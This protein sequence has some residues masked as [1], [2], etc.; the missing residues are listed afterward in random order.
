MRFVLGLVGRTWFITVVT[1]IICAGFLAKA[2]NSI[3]EAEAL[4][5]APASKVPVVAPPKPILAARTKLDGTKISRNIFCSTCEPIVLVDG[6]KTYT[7]EPAVLIATMLGPDPRAT[8]RVLASEAQGSWGIGERIPGVGR[9]DRIGSTSIDVVDV[10]GHVG[11][12]SLLDARAE[13]QPKKTDA[14]TSVP[15]APA[16]PFADRVRKIADNDY[17]VDRQL[18]RDLVTGTSKPNGVRAVPQ[19]KGSEV[20][21]IRMIGVRGGSVAAAL[22]L[23]SNDVIAAIDG[24]PIKNVQ[25]LLDL[26]AKLDNIS[27]VELSGTRAGKPLTLTLRL[28]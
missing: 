18:V 15:A 24:E 11:T 9:I 3:I 26:Y 5:D 1:V 8:V 10:A 7:G 25:Q 14:A 19:M 4:T 6:P 16:D 27:A 20:Q 28:R 13:G 21:G 23:K 22:G 12:I 2:A 17:E